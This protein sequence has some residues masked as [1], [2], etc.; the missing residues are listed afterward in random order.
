MSDPIFFVKSPGFGSAPMSGKLSEINGAIYLFLSARPTFC[1]RM[2]FAGDTKFNAALTCWRPANNSNTSNRD[3]RL[4]L[5]SKTSITYNLHT[6]YN[7]ILGCPRKYAD[8]F[9]VLRYDMYGGV[10]D[11]FL[12]IL[13]HQSILLICSEQAMQHA[14]FT[15]TTLRRFFL[16]KAIV[17][18]A[19]LG[20]GGSEGLPAKAKH[21]T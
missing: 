1:R 14:V 2:M 7:I 8:H 18:S 20:S 17:F 16:S 19:F 13:K 9:L 10:P 3:L 4:D 21:S 12:F 15:H 11:H 6:M 5:S